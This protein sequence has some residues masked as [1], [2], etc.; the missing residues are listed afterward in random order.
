MSSTECDLSCQT[1][2]IINGGNAASLIEQSCEALQ[3]FFNNGGTLKSGSKLIDRLNAIEDAA[4]DLQKEVLDQV[5]Y[6]GRVGKML[7]CSNDTPLSL[8]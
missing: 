6:K 5:G 3:H 2:I 4:V 1:K 8:K 7:Q